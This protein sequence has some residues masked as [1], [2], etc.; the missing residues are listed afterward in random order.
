[1]KRFDTTVGIQQISSNVRLIQLYYNKIKLVLYN[2][3]SHFRPHT[4]FHV[5][6]QHIP[7]TS[8]SPK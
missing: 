1:M 3:S 4:L 7:M 2:M 6:I 8:Y 5:W